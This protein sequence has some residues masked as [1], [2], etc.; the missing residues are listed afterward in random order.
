MPRAASRKSPIR[1]PTWTAPCAGDSPGSSARLK[2]GTRSASRKWRRRS[3]EE[4]QA[5]PP[6]V[7]KL[8]APAKKSI[9]RARRRRNTRYFDLAA[10]G[11]SRPSRAARH[12]HSQIAERALQGDRQ[13]NSGASLIDL[14][15]GVLCCEFH[16]KM[17]AIG[18]DIA[19]HAA[20]RREHAL[21]SEFDAMVVANQAP[22]FR[23]ARI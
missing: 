11:T 10:A 13:K 2:F 6:L 5:L 20:G 23:P 22:I 3:K 7:A 16:A 9:L 12:H 15:D 8:L 17:N 14:G 21:A 4:G 19:G 1:S 18:D